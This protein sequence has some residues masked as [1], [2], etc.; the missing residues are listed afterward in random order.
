M[1]Y[2]EEWWRISLKIVELERFTIGRAS[3]SISDEMRVADP[4]RWAAEVR[5][6]LPEEC[7]ARSR[8]SAL[9]GHGVRQLVEE[10]PVVPWPSPERHQRTITL[11]ASEMLEGEGGR[12]WRTFLEGLARGLPPRLAAVLANGGEAMAEGVVSLGLLGFVS[13]GGVRLD[14]ADAIWAALE[15][16]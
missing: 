7:L 13:G 2:G 5:P 6:M 4:E 10:S 14:H 16:K 12:S 9:A 11:W 8:A 1:D 15:A 3:S